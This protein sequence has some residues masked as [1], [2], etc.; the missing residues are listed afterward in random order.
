[1][2]FNPLLGAAGFDS[3]TLTWRNALEFRHKLQL[4]YVIRI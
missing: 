1:M 3:R 4:V 2:Y